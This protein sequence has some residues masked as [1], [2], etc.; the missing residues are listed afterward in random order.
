[1]VQVTYEV[2]GLAPGVQYKVDFIVTVRGV[3]KTA[4]P[5]AEGVVNGVHTWIVDGDALFGPNV[6]D[7]KAHMHIELVPV[8]ELE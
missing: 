7:E 1:M 2:F 5:P 8:A 4:H 3:T 6:V